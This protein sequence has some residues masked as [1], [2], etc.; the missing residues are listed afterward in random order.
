MKSKLLFIGSIVLMIV[1]IALK[2]ITGLPFNDYVMTV[3]LLVIAMV[4][5][6]SLCTITE[7]HK[8]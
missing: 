4:A 8:E 1:L 3:I 6:Y 2:Y 7:N 5:G